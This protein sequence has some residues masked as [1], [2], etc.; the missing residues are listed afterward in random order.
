MN[1][2]W[3]VPRNKRPN[4]ILVRLR[5]LA[6]LVTA[7]VGILATTFVIT[8]GSDVDALETNIDQTLRWVLTGLTVLVNS[9]VFVVPVPARDDA[10]ALAAA[11]HSGR[12]HDGG[13]LAGCCSCSAP[14]YVTSVIK[15]TSVTNQ[16][17]A[18]VFGM[19]AYLYLAAI[20]VVFGVEINVVKAH[21]LYPRALLTPFTDNVDLTEADRRAYADYAV[22]AAHQGLRSRSTYGSNTTASTS[23]PRRPQRRAAST[24]S[25]T[26]TPPPVT[27]KTSGQPHD[28]H[29]SCGS[30]PSWASQVV[31]GWHRLRSVAPCGGRPDGRPVESPP[32]SSRPVVDGFVRVSD[33]TR[34]RP[35]RGTTARTSHDHPTRSPAHAT[36]SPASPRAAR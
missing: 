34:E 18:T 22:G 21:R 30:S 24:T 10:Q 28:H 15:N 23:A 35:R 25:P 17:F 33:A 12:G 26:R 11:A 5:S 32:L 36:C 31:Y 14:M 20:F 3:A 7:G 2:A 1:V 4:P 16:I 8:L 6:L 27:D 19:I 13:A 9:A 29:W